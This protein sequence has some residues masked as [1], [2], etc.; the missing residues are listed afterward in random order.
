MDLPAP[1]PAAR[2]FARVTDPCVE[3][4]RRLLY[5]IPPVA[6]CATLAGAKGF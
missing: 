6:L 2:L 1:S 3:R 4:T 5:D